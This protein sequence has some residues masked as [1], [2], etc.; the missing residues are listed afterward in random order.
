MINLKLDIDRVLD[1]ITMNDINA[2]QSQMDLHYTS[3]LEKTG[4]GKEF[5]GWLN[6]PQ[7]TTEHFLN[8]VKFDAEEIK[9]RAKIVVVIGIGGSYLGSRA[10]IE[11]L[12]HNFASLKERENPYIIYAGN[13]L[14][15]D[16]MADLLDILDK[17]EYSIIVISKSGTTTEPA[18]A[19]R[20]IKNHLENKYGE[21]SAKHRI[22]AITDATKGA[23]RKLS[24]KEGYLSYK[25]PGDVGGRFSVLTCVGLIPIAVA[26]FDIK[27]LI[28]GAKEMQEFLTST[29]SIKENPAVM[30]AAVRNAL[31]Q[32]GK[33]IEVLANYSPNLYYLT[34]WWKQL[35]GESEGKENKGI[36]PV[37]M[38][39]TAD[40]HSL[41]QYM[42]EGLRNIF[43]TVLSVE[44]SNR[45]I[46]IPMLSDNSD[47]L[48]YIAGK[49][50]Q[51]VNK[52]A[53]AGTMLA[54]VDGKVPNI[55]ISIPQLNEENL[56]QLIYFFEFSC[57][58]SGY[59][60]GVNPFDQ[61]GVETYKN[62][63]FA[64]LEKPGFEKNNK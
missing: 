24:G 39:F 25:I 35:F 12:S 18:I 61:P 33:T 19:F 10:I 43:E 48:N 56:G 47:E 42:Q 62:N 63:M 50:L 34:E 31:Y 2:Y 14:S 41:G 4:K 46:F 9:K 7:K 13:N 52:M 53:K 28:T 40:L 16:Y 54:H 36:L 15:E 51:H 60:L 6:I 23:L 37:G 27:K 21:Q 26:G 11:A 29:S 49:S 8:K 22:I 55:H 20:I 1:F 3:L 59:M 38:N 64:L 44:N 57:A 30:Y 45:E 5:L 17:Y 32:K 58:L